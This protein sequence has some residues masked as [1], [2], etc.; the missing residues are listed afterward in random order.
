LAAEQG[1]EAAMWRWTA[2]QL[3]N[4]HRLESWPVS[5]PLAHT[6]HVSVR[7]AARPC[8][9]SGPAGTLARLAMSAI[10]ESKRVQTDHGMVARAVEQAELRSSLSSTGPI[11]RASCTLLESNLR[12]GKDFPCSQPR[13]ESRVDPTPLCSDSTMRQTGLG[14]ACLQECCSTSTQVQGADSH[15]PAAEVCISAEI[16]G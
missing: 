11:S 7:V 12:N 3:R 8:S 2:A 4:R 5:L 10:A 6:K 15:S 1:F 16:C 13:L 9:E 14:L